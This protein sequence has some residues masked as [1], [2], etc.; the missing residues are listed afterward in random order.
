MPVRTLPLDPNDQ[1]G[2][3]ELPDLPVLICMPRIEQPNI[4]PGEVPDIS[5]H[6]NQ[7]VQNGH[8]GNLRVGCGGRTAGAISVAH[9]APP[10]GGGAAVERQDT[11]IELPSKVL[12]DPPLESF[13]ALLL[14]YFS[15]A[16]N[17]LSDGLGGEEEIRRIPG[18]EPVD[19][20]LPRSWPDCLADHV[21]VQKKGHQPSSAGRPVELSRSMCSSTSV[22]GEARRKATNS[23][24][25]RALGVASTGCSD[26]RMN[27]ASSP[28]ERRAPAIA[29]TSGA[30]PEGT[31]TS[32]RRAPLVATRLR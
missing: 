5:R 20:R 16:S 29:L 32:T 22:K 9:E 19:D 30:S 18:F 23:E 3:S 21:G 4:E 13:A 11:P 7:S 24:P 28:S 17:E 26:L 10:N 31:V 15:S 8:R 27:S 14:P 12:L 6:E 2:N 25:V 1:R